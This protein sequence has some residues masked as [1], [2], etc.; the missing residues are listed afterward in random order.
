MRKKKKKKQKPV[1]TQSMIGKIIDLPLEDFEKELI[2]QK[3]NIGTM[4]NLILNLEGAYNELRI[5]KDAVIKAG[6]E[7]TIPK[8]QATALT[9]GIYAEMIKTEQKI[10]YL[11][12][13][14]K[15]LVNVDKTLN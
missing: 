9:E 7:G 6:F 8:D 14:T 3:V 12:Q 15:E 5:R 4:N 11:K 1:Q 10:T 13:R 2:V